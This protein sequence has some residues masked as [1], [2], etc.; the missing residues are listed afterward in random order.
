MTT[1]NRR[2]S[3]R[4]AE[5]EWETWHTTNSTHETPPWPPLHLLPG[6]LSTHAEVKRRLRQSRSELAETKVCLRQT[7][8]QLEKEPVHKLAFPTAHEWGRSSTRRERVLALVRSERTLA[9]LQEGLLLEAV[10][11]EHDLDWFERGLEYLQPAC[12]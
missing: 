11:L 7:R 4:L 2:R 8:Y 1:H 12:R 10:D 5:R 9:Q 3:E 6:L